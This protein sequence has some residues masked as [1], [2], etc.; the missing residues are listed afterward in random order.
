M[1]AKQIET[2]KLGNIRKISKFRKDIPKW[3]VLRPG[4]KLLIIRKSTYHSFWVMSFTLFQKFCPA[5]CS[6]IKV[7]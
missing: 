6:K 7:C 2:K 1:S 4:V 3:P 5:F